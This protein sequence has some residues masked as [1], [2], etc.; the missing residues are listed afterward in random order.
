MENMQSKNLM[1][2]HVHIANIHTHTG[3]IDL[4]IL[5]FALVILSLHC[6]FVRLAR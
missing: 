6:L 3:F 4:H 1:Q 5:Y 2:T